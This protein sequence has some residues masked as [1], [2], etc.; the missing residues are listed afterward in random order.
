MEFSFATTKVLRTLGYL[1]RNQPGGHINN[2]FRRTI[3]LLANFTVIPLVLWHIVYETDTF[4][5]K[6]EPVLAFFY[7]LSSFIFYSIMLLQR[8]Y[9]FDTLAKLQLAVNKRTSVF[10][11]LFCGKME[12]WGK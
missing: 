1:D 12:L 7:G 4:A 11:S 2:I 3:C 8:R 10:D 6:V 5:Q 9:I